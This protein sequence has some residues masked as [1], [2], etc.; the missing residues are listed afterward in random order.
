MSMCGLCLY[1]CGRYMCVHVNGMCMCEVSVCVSVCVAC[2][3]VRSVY[4]CAVYGMCVMCVCGVC[5]WCMYDVCVC[6]VYM[7]RGVY[8]C[9]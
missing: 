9:V 6:G 7:C 4:V 2:E 3:Y 1:D 8:I 5:E